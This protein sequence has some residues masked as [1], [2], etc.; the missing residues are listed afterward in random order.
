MLVGAGTSSLNLNPGERKAVV[1]SLARA[2]DQGHTTAVF[3]LDENGARNPFRLRNRDGRYIWSN[4][5]ARENGIGV[6]SIISY[7][8]LYQ[9]CLYSGNTGNKVVSL[10]LQF[11]PKIVSSSFW[12]YWYPVTSFHCKVP[13]NAHIDYSSFFQN[14]VKRTRPVWSD[15]NFGWNELTWLT[16]ERNDP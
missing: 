10:A 9:G 12:R 5:E 8:R 13:F 6:G 14:S 3:C 11:A 7:Q 15:L 16:M 1:I 4:Q 2:N